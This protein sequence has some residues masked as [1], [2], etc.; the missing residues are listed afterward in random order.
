MK[1][2]LATLS[3]GTALLLSTQVSAQIRFGGKV[4][5][6]YLITSQKIQPDPKNPPT[7]PKGLGL[8]FGVYGEIPFSDLVGIRPELGFS[9]R[10]GKSEVT[11][12]Q[13]LTNNTEVTGNQGAYTGTRDFKSETDQRLTY[14]QINAPLSLSPTEGLR[15]MFGPSFNFL[16][17]GKQN[18]DETTTFKG[19][20]TGQN[21]QGQTVTVQVDE[22]NF[23]TTKKKGSAAIKD[24]TKADVA[25]MAGVGYTLPVGFDMD[26][27]FYRGLTT[28]YDRSEG[29][30]RQRY[31]TNL[32]ELS[33]G[34]TFG[35]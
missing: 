33:V 4:G 23:E 35:N 6:N 15:V 13:T 9:F 26:L 8:V 17:G 32:V 19:S 20:V 25:A 29:T 28:T 7:N 10:R 27:R 12:N 22:Q 1:R 16:M 30:A 3:V 14:F 21:Q 24:F 31:W 11:D 18:V 34:W 2:I 5:G